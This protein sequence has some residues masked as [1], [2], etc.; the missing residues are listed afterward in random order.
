MERIR[1]PEQIES[2]YQPME[3]LSDCVYFQRNAAEYT[4]D[5]IKVSE[6]LPFHVDSRQYIFREFSLNN[7]VNECDQ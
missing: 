2:K 4:A 5:D 6:F 1:L 3:D 7:F